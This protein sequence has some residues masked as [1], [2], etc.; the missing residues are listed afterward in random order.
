MVRIALSLLFALAPSPALAWNALGHKVIAEIAWQQ[1]EPAARRSIVDTLRR[2]PRFDD[3]FAKR[4]PAEVE[5]A[6]QST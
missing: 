3:D 2:H 1:L 6:D 5:G 4:M